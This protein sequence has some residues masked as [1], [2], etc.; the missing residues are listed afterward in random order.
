M[1]FYA[2]FPAPARG[3]ARALRSFAARG[4]GTSMLAL[5]STAA[6]G[7]APDEQGSSSNAGSPAASGQPQTSMGGSGASANGGSGASGSG[8][9][10]TSGGAAC[11]EEVSD[12]EWAANC[13]ACAGEDAC[14][15]CLCTSCEQ[16]TRECDATE[17]CREIAACVQSAGCM[18]IDCYCGTDTPADCANGAGKGPCK[19]TI[20]AAPGGK[21][22]TLAD[23]SGGPASDAVAQV[24]L[25]M[26]NP[27][28]CGSVCN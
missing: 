14:A 13:L 9:G 4:V 17:G 22:P 2:R 6:C 15:T 20:L 3:A 23:P 7:S 10:G 24:A 19:D 25:C 18:G 16:A 12:A 27:D 11:R 8:A 28:T 5:I 26:Q 1:T 21:A